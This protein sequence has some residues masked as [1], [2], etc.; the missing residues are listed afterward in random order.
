MFA[1][2]VG[3]FSIFYILSIIM[4]VSCSDWFLVWV[5]LE[6]NMMSFI[7][8]IY[9]RSSISVETCMKY[10][11]IQSMGS[12]ILMMMFY[13]EFNWFEYVCLS[14]LSYKMGGGPFYFWFPSVCDSLSWG[15][16]LLLMTVQKVLPLLMI[17]FLV[18]MFLWLIIMSS[19]IMGALGSMNQ[20]SV[21]RLMAYSSV[22][23]IG[24]ILMGNFMAESMWM[25]YLMMYSALIAGVIWTLM[26]DKILEVGMLEKMSSKWSFV[27]GML[28]MGGMPPML[29][30]YLK[31]WLLYNL[32]MVDFSLLV[33]MI[34]MSVLMFYVYLR[35]SYSVIMGS[36]SMKC[37]SSVIMNKKIMSLDLMYMM[38][39]NIGVSL[40]LML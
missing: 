28:S 13:S 18:S 7:A 16:C 25:I 37:W 14:V 19:L 38:G 29:G 24:W 2:S 31:W 26:K 20:K 40:W 34:L 33:L 11:F 39:L 12:G 30:F 15:S 21:K 32:M 17:S 27:L 10:F 8:L 22:H 35:I 4:T 6:I 3:F 9:D 36:M 1:Q 23:H 5:G